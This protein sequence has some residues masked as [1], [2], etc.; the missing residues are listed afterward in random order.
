MARFDVYPDAGT[1]TYLLDCR[2]DAL[3][4]LTTRFVV[5]LLPPD[6]GPPLVARLNPVFRIKGE[7]VAMYTQFAAAVPRRQL[8]DP[9]ASLTAEDRRIMNALDVLLTGY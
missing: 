8:S 4:G 2:A 6:E 3:S 9:I 5:P 7:D 1:S